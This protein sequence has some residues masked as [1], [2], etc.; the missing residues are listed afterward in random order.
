[1]PSTRVNPLAQQSGLIAR[2]KMVSV[3]PPPVVAKKHYMAGQIVHTQPQLPTYI[4]DALI[5][6]IKY[7][8][9]R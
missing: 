1:M 9:G 6:N 7:A 8:A 5:T 4:P 2:A 3:L